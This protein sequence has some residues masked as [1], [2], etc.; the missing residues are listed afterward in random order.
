L[1]ALADQR[2]VAVVSSNTHTQKATWKEPRHSLSEENRALELRDNPPGCADDDFGLSRNVFGVLG[3]PLDV[4][5]LEQL[6]ER[7]GEAV[8][9]RE[10]FWL[11]TPNVNFL[12][13]SRTD[14][15]FRESLLSSDL[16][17][18]DG[19][20]LIWIARLLGIPIQRRLSG[21][22]IFDHLRLRN[23]DGHK[24]KV[25]LFGGTDGIADGLGKSI[26]AEQRGMACVG[27]LNPGFGSIP[28]ISTDA[29]FQDINS[30]NADLLT[31]FLSA[32]KAQCWLLQNQHRLEVPVRAQF[33]ATVNLQAGTIR[34]APR[35]VQRMGFE[36][37]W[38]IKEEP[39]LWRRYWKDGWGLLSLL[40][41]C[42]LPLSV[43]YLWRR[44]SGVDRNANFLARVSE[45]AN[46]VTVVLVGP[47]IDRNIDPAI[48]CF[49]K[50]LQLGKTLGIDLSQVS[51]VDPRFFGL[52]VAVRKELRDR[53]SRLT[54][55]GATRRIHRIFNLNGFGFLL[56]SDA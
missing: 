30:S 38:R 43:H 39:Y 48:A 42:V 19:M 51:T 9:A 3:I 1:R 25:F 7:V 45:E 35:L 20:P 5:D 22:D 8:A 32:R 40:A 16:C 36:W 18:V 54:L 26:N 10:P 11:S 27:T 14:A 12:M 2:D 31:V 44:L 28:A 53:G 46:F 4:L 33:G 50:A 17:P 6:L 13:T 41:T 52:L 49:R 15:E 37:L 47:A 21:S 55:F 56:R 23:L 34:R 24:L 29:I